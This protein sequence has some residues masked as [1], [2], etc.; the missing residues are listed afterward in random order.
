MTTAYQTILKDVEAYRP[1]RMSN[2]EAADLLKT[3]KYTSGVSGKTREA[4][5]KAI[6]ALQP[7]IMP[8]MESILAE[9]CRETGV[10]EEQMMSKGRY[11]EF[12]EARYIFF[13]LTYRYTGITYAAIGQRVNRVH[14]LVYYGICKV[15]EW[16]ANPKINPDVVKQIEQ[17]KDRIEQ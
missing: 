13:W 17:I 10:T 11:R 15:N 1:K 3:L 2:A 6:A 8:T 12:S 5:D 4:I 7:S 9:V 14:P 16:M